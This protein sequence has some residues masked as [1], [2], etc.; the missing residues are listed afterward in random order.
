MV[1]AFL[2]SELVT[3]LCKHFPKH[4]HTMTPMITQDRI[5]FGLGYLRA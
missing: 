4:V 1:D 2:V 3:V 5:V